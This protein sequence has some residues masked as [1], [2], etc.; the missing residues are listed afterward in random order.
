MGCGEPHWKRL[1]QG[2]RGETASP[3]RACMQLSQRWARPNLPPAPDVIWPGL[4]SRKNAAHRSP[5]PA[6]CRGRACLLHA[7]QT[8]TALFSPPQ[9]LPPACPVHWSTQKCAFEVGG[10][11]G[12]GV[13]PMTVILL[14]WVPPSLG[15]AGVQQLRSPLH[16]HVT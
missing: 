12:P 9:H 7:A 4:I 6:A 3:C 10:R 16:L 15:D 1:A 2:A 5:S 13:L 14:F 11:H 8:Q